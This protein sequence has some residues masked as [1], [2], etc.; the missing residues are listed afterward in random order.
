MMGVPCRCSPNCPCR[1]PWAGEGP[2]DHVEPS[3]HPGGWVLWGQPLGADVVYGFV[4]LID[5]DDPDTWAMV[6]GQLD[7]FAEALGL[8]HDG[9][10][11]PV[12]IRV[13]DGTTGRPLEAWDGGSDLA[14][15]DYPDG[16]T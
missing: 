8:R 3:T 4:D 13:Y 1:R 7:L 11:P 6:L 2:P 5:R 16:L 9:A 15:H 14:S 10:G 12:L